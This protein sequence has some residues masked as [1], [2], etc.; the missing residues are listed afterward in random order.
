MELADKLNYPS[1]GYKLKAITAFKIFIYHRDHAL[2]D[3]EAVIPK[4]IRENKHVINFPKTNN[5]CVFHCI[6]WHTFQSPK[7]DPRRIQAQVKEAFKRYCSFKG[8]KYSLSLF[9]S[10]KP[11]DLLQLDEVEDCFQLGINVYKMDVVSG[12]VECIRRSDKGYET[13]DILSF[14]NHALYIKNID[15]LQA[16]YQCPKCEMVFVSAERVK[17]HKKNQCELVN[18]E[19]FPAEPT[20]YKPAQNAIRSLLTKYSI[21]N[22]DQYIDHF[23]VYDCEAILNSTATQHGENTVFT[24]EHIPVSVSVADSLTEEVRCFVNDDPMMLLT[25]MFKY[26]GDVSVKIQQYNVNKYKLLLQ[27][28][29]NAHG[30][31]GMEIP[32]VNLGKKYNMTDVM[33]WIKEGKYG[34]FFDFHNILGLESKG[35]ITGN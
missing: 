21:K 25:D 8:V 15:M 30:L 10:F 3:S 2:G 5:K 1:S 23:I 35:L 12:N 7:K 22:A 26:I 9:R 20:I 31:T 32:G 13:M 33:N 11:I 34:S 14:E 18:I 6:A 24:N 28:I 16:K 27:K 4:I 17:N 19:S 29:I